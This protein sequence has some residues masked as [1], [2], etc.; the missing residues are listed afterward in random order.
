[1][2][3]ASVF[4][5]EDCRFESYRGHCYMSLSSQREP[6]SLLVVIADMVCDGPR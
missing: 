5:T 2:D 1:M 6:A 4:G 3:K